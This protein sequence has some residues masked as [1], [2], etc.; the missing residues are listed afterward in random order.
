MTIFNSYASLPEGILQSNMASLEI[1]TLQGDCHVMD[2]IIEGNREFSSK[3]SPG[4][5][6]P[7]SVSGEG[8]GC[9]RLRL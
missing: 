1:P 3:G 6:V 4:P 8:Q 5:G 2:K 7:T 9:A